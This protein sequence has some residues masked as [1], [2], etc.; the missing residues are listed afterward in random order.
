MHGKLVCQNSTYYREER[1]LARVQETFRRMF[2]NIEDLIKPVMV[3]AS[4]QCWWCRYGYLG[5]LKRPS[6]NIR[7]WCQ[8][9]RRGPCLK[10]QFERISEN[11]L[12][13]SIGDDAPS[14]PH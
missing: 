4:P 6:E 1:L 14:V 5:I 8:E 7:G 3:C 11:T 2:A 12:A 9:T 10:R 13:A